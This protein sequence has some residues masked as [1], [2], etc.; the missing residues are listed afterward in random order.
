MSRTG[1]DQASLTDA[2]ERM[3]AKQDQTNRLLQKGN[4]ITSDLSDDF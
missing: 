4:R 3:V 1:T 2:L